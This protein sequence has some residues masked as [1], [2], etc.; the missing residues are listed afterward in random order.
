M[1]WG[2]AVAKGLFE[3]LAGSFGDRGVV[4]KEGGTCS[5]CEGDGQ[6]VFTANSITGGTVLSE[7]A[8]TPRGCNPALSSFLQLFLGVHLS[9]TRSK[10]AVVGKLSEPF[11]K[12]WCSGVVIRSAS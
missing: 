4:E 3:A 2:E 12:R 5:G 11:W 8:T 6:L 9:L 7:V 10:I 1:G